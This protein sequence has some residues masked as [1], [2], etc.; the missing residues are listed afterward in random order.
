[1]RINCGGGGDN[2]SEEE[3]DKNP[4]WEDDKSAEKEDMNLA[5]QFDLFDPSLLISPQSM[6]LFSNNT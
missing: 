2:L 4:A 1:V 3:G 6:Q 5:G